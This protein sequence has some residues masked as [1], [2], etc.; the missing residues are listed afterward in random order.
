MN[1]EQRVIQVEKCSF[2]PLVYSTS[3]AM[4]PQARVFHKRLAELI[5]AKTNEEYRD[6]ISTM[7][8]GL[9]FVHNKL[10]IILNLYYWR[11]IVIDVGWLCHVIFALDRLLVLSTR[12]SLLSL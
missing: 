10:E 3:G 8:F 12:S 6:V 4:A 9:T 1:Y 2:T 11:I 7:D 5:A